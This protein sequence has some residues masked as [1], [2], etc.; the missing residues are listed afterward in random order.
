MLLTQSESF[1]PSQASV[2]QS[3]PFA[4]EASWL[5]GKWEKLAECLSAATED[6]NGDFNVGIGRALLSLHQK[7]HHRFAEIMNELRNNAARTLSPATTS[8]L[9]SCHGNLLRFHILTE[10]EIIS[11]VNCQDLPDQ[12]AL[13]TCLNQRLEVLGAFS[14]DKQ[15]LLGL[16][17]ATMQLS[18]YLFSH[19]SFRRS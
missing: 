10:V 15:Y 17:R 13:L 11:G 4:V 12:T 14:S 8:S 9:Q 2:L 18:R 5:T 19:S 1:A 7:D 3:R 16:R 6:L